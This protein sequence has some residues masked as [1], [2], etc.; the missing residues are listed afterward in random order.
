LGAALA[1]VNHD[2]RADLLVNND[3]DFADQGIAP[4]G[5]L[6]AIVVSL[7]TGNATFS[8]VAEYDLGEL[9]NGSLPVAD[10]NRDGNPDL[11]VVLNSGFDVLLGN[12]DGTFQTPVV[13]PHSQWSG[14][15]RE[16]VGDFNAD[17]RP[18]VV[19]ADGKT[20]SVFLNQP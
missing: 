9:G 19:V 1:D 8:Q 2:G 20:L 6:A 12:G 10:F 3:D 7:G 17:R 15:A 13:V 16:A 11:A 18:D 5:D 14:D 4:G